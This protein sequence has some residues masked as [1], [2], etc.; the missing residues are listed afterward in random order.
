MNM[1]DDGYVNHPVPLHPD[2]LACYDFSLVSRGTHAVND[3]GG[4]SR[5]SMWYN[6]VGYKRNEII[7]VSVIKQDNSYPY[8]KDGS[9]LDEDE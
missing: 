1:G 2:V 7:T 3:C 8:T 9:V 5:D 4:V 6:G